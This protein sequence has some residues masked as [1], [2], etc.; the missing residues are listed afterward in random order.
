MNKI[1]S[2]EKYLIKLTH[3]NIL[4]RKQNIKSLSCKNRPFKL[5]ITIAA[6]QAIGN[7]RRRGVNASSTEPKTRE[8]IPPTNNVF[9]PLPSCTTERLNEPALG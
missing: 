8:E 4:I 3:S 1:F 5:T 6:R 2:Y 7:D 9:P